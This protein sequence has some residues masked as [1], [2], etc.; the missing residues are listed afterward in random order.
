MPAAASDHILDVDDLR[1]HIRTKTGV[2][3][4]VDGVGFSI[5]R[6]EIFGL[7]GESGSG[8]SM[9]AFSILRLLPPHGYIAGGSI[10]FGGRDL[11]DLTESEMRDLRGDRIAMVFQDPMSSLN[12]VLTVGY[13]IAEVLRQHRGLS[14][15][16]AR[17]RPCASWR[18]SRYRRPGRDTAPTPT[19]SAAAC[20][21]A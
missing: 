9:T 20:A 2:V 10:R 6:S 3:R 5:R 15:G 21:S 19:S 4:S 17:T 7:A 1:T 16:A 11:R 13:Q 8:K 14:S 12:P 18:W